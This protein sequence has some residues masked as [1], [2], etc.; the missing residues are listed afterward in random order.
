M[1]K[2]Q[3]L[4][5]KIKC[6]VRKARFPRYLHRYGPK[7]YEFWQHAFALIAKAMFRL[8]YR[9]TTRYL[10]LLGFRV[11]SKSTI[12]RYAKKLPLNLWQKLLKAT[13]DHDVEIAA[14]DGTG[15]SRIT[16]SWHYIKR[17][18]GKPANTF[19]KFSMCVDVKKRKILSLRIRAKRASDFKDVKNLINNLPAKPNLCIM[20]KGY[21]AEWLHQ[22][23]HEKNI[24]SIIP[25]RRP[26][27]PIYR[28]KGFFRKQMKKSFDQKT[29]NQRNIVESLIFA[30]KKIF[31]D[32]V[33]SKLISSAR[34]EVYS[35]AI[36]YNLFLFLNKVLGQRP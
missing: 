7:T 26:D 12:H 3:K 13:L 20:D 28:T 10:R 18:N 34:A 32:S 1:K 6:L 14:I 21:D 17:I 15:L 33:S 4:I 25:T 23:F 2:E 27:L 11:G 35:R 22:Y 5:N 19:Y 8:S 36:A 16:Q 31:G 24:K 9:R 30:F 29:Y